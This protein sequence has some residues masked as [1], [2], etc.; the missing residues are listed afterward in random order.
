MFGIQQEV[1]TVSMEIHWGV[2]IFIL[3]TDLEI[4][5]S[6]TAPKPSLRGI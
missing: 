6:V 1:G 5:L 3:N 4:M 2:E